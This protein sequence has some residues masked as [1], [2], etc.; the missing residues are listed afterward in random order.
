MNDKKLK[1]AIIYRIIDFRTIITVKTFNILMSIADIRIPV[2][3]CMMMTFCAHN[4]EN[5]KMKKFKNETM[6]SWWRSG[7]LDFFDKN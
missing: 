1:N 6:D 4:A 3:I 7:K 2:I 5:L